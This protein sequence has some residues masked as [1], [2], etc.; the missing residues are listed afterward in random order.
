VLGRNAEGGAAG[1]WDLE[2]GRTSDFRSLMLRVRP[3]EWVQNQAVVS[4]E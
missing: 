1:N 2:W 4:Q 3:V